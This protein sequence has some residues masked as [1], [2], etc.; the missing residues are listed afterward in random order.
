MDFDAEQVFKAMADQVRRRILQLVSR[1]ELSVSEVV[2]CLRLPQ[3]TVSRHLKV[4]REAGLILDRRKGTVVLYGAAD[5]NSD[6]VGEPVCLPEMLLD[7]VAVETLPAVIERRL[8]AVVDRR[9]ASHGSF[10]S[11]YAHRWDE[12]RIEAFGD[13]FHLEALTAL[14]PGEWTVADIGAGTGWLLPILSSTFWR[15]IAVEP[16]PEMLAEA[17]RVAQT[18]KLSNV[19]LKRGDLGR[20]PIESACVDM[21][22]AALVLHHVPSPAEAVAELFRVTKPGGRLLIVEQKAH[23]N[24]SFHQ[25]MGDRWRGFSSVELGECVASAG[26]SDVVSRSLSHESRAATA[27]DVPELFTITARRGTESPANRSHE[28][29]AEQAGIETEE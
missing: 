15:V 4:L 1:H 21:V 24:E 5:R 3:S 28:R 25:R 2:E 6:W 19:E 18:R 9:V 27:E 29:P 14:L 16:I 23:E 8:V 13:A 11:R 26:F 12:M 22:C 17:T 20:L 10:F 7:W